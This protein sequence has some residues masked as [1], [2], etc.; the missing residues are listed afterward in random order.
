MTRRTLILGFTCL[1]C[2]V[3]TGTAAALN[4][5]TQKLLETQSTNAQSTNGG[6]SNSNFPGNVNTHPNY[7]PTNGVF[8]QPSTSGLG[9]IPAPKR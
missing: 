5:R 2:L 7:G 1:C 6:K 4:N 9:N 3:E 8:G